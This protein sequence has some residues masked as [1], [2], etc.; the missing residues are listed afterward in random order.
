MTNDRD[1]TISRIARQ[2]LGIETLESRRMDR[3]DFHERAVWTIK[4]ALERAYEAGRSA[5]PPTRCT[6]PA[7]GRELTITPVNPITPT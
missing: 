5:G 3:L 6:C 1:T 7:C 4:D 2:A